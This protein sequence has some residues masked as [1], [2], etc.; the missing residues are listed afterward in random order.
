MKTFNAYLLILCTSVH[1]PVEV[2][3]HTCR[4]IFTI[5]TNGGQS[6]APYK[7]AVAIKLLNTFTNNDPQDPHCFKEQVKIKFEATKAIVGRF[8]N[9]T[10]ALTHLLSKAE[11]PLTWDQ[12]CAMPEENRLMWEQKADALN[13]AMIYV[14]NSKNETAKK[15]LHLAY[16]QGNHTAYPIQYQSGSSIPIIPCSFISFVAFTLVSWLGVG[17]LG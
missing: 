14:M 5:T 13:Q 11:P 10:A 16:S 8:P 17:I 4:L 12:Y 2:C 6:Y 9:K 1:I 7:Q 3:P 15:D